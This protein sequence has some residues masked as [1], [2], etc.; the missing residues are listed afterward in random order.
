MNGVIG[1]IASFPQEKYLFLEKLQANLVKMIKGVRCLSHEQWRS[2]SYERKTVFLKLHSSF[3][4][5]YETAVAACY[6]SVDQ[7]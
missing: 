5:C 3:V 1:V 2:F 7:L 6:N 4:A